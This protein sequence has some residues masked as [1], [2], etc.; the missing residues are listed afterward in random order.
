MYKKGAKEFEKAREKVPENSNL[1]KHVRHEQVSKEK[2]AFGGSQSTRK[3]KT[4]SPVRHYYLNY[5]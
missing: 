1:I 4:T 2:L 3:K 5:K